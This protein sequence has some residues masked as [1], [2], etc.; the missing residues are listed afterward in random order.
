MK[1]EFNMCWKWKAPE[2]NHIEIEHQE[3]HQS[4]LKHR[5]LF[6]SNYQQP[7]C[8]IF[9]TTKLERSARMW[10][11]FNHFGAFQQRIRK[12]EYKSQKP[13]N[14]DE[15]I[16]KGKEK[17]Q[18]GSSCWVWPMY[19]YPG[20]MP[21][22]SIHKMKVISV[23]TFFMITYEEYS[24]FV[25]LGYCVTYGLGKRHDNLFQITLHQ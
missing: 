19:I 22:Q 25:A 9:L 14:P 11:T 20:C 13:L 7:G 8:K 15:T 16:S 21:S 2:G 24:H 6:A 23:E 17:L 10:L 18:N 12:Q 3:T 4:N 5:H 1:F